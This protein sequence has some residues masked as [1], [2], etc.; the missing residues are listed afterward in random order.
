MASDQYISAEH[1]RLALVVRRARPT[2]RWAAMAGHYFSTRNCQTSRHV[3]RE[4]WPTP[5]LLLPMDRGHLH[6]AIERQRLTHGLGSIRQTFGCGL[7]EIL[8]EPRHI[9]PEVTHG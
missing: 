6:R 8:A 4:H 7:R 3:D 1:V 5:P 9:V 2:T